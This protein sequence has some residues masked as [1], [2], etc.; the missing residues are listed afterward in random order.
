MISSR[1]ITLHVIAID[2]CEHVLEALGS[3]PAS[4]IDAVSSGN[5]L[6]ALSSG[7]NDALIATRTPIDLIVVGVARHPVRRMFISD[8]RRAY[9]DVLTVVLRREE[10]KG[11]DSEMM[12]RGEFLLSDRHRVGDYAIVE[13]LRLLFPLPLCGHIYKEANYDIVREVMHVIAEKFSDPELNLN[14]VARRLPISPARLSRILNQRVG[15]SFRGLLRQTRIEEAK[16]LLA[17]GRYSVKEVASR[18]GFSD[19]HYF[20]R[21]FKE[22]TGLNASDYQAR[23]GIFN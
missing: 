15:V 9:P 2:C 4:S 17:S 21:S 1:E 23:S 22:V 19:S 11:D 3:V 18:A 20:S 10:N 7:D 16:R 14:K 8:L 13:A 6:N 12:I 5:R